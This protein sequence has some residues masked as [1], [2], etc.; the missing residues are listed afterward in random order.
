MVGAGAIL[1]PGVVV[2]ARATVAAGA[3]VASD[4][5]AESTVLGIPARVR[6]P[7]S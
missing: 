5:P 4:V 7:T 3:V 6:P 1:L 2:G